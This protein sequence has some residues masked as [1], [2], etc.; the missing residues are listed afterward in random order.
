MAIVRGGTPFGSWDFS[1]GTHGWTTNGLVQ[2]A[3]TTPAGWVMDLQ[4]PDPSLTSPILDFP[5]NEFVQV[6][7]RMRS[8]SGA[9]GQLYFGPVFSEANSRGFVV[10][11]DDQWHE[12][13]INL[14]PL[15]AGARLRLDPGHDAGRV[16][17]S[18]IRA[19]T[20][21]APPPEPWASPAELRRKKLIGSGQYTTSGGESAVTSR[22]LA[23]NPAF[24]A[25]YPFDGLVLPVVVE[26]AVAVRL[27]LPA[28][29][30]F[31]HELLWNTVELP[32]AVIASAVADLKS[33]HWGGVTD[34]FLNYTLVDGARGR[35]T[36][37]FANDRDWAILEHNAT[38]AARLCREAGFQGFWLD[39]EQYGNYRWRTAT[40]VPE[41][42]PDRPKNLKFPL[43]KDTPELLRR[44]GA[45]WIR[46]VQ[47]EL[48]AVKIM[49]TFAWSPD[50][51]GYEPLKGVNGFLDGVLD[52]IQAP[53]QLIHGYENT[54]YYGQG[55]GTTHTREGFAGDRNRYAAARESM[56]QWRAFSANPKKY[57]AFL[58]VGM[59]AWVEDDPWSLWSGYTSG[60]TSSFWSNLPLALA[61]SD[62]YV[63]VWSEHTHYAHGF[64]A[65]GRINPFLASLHNQTFNTDREPVV[66]I[67]EDFASDPLGQGWYFDFDM[68]DI[69]RRQNPTHA[70]PLMTVDALPYDWS[71]EQRSV[72]I[73]GAWPAKDRHQPAAPSDGQRRRFVRPV[74]PV[75]RA[76]NFHAELDFMVASFGTHPENPMVLGLF[77]HDHPVRE[78]SLTF[79][80]EAPNRCRIVLAHE[81]KM[82]TFPLSTPNGLQTNHTYR[83]SL[84]YTASNGRLRATLNE[85]RLGAKPLARVQGRIRT[86][87]GSFDWDEFGAALAETPGPVAPEAGYRCWLKKVVFQR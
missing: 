21:P 75:N 2:N 76:K 6:N 36:P 44:R 19:E 67:D 35:F 10:Q 66:S 5:A 55:P 51:N 87:N 40:G 59:A 3:R 38:M 53:A 83:V 56:R 12:Y 17:V 70:V 57:D 77:R 45:Q 33:I 34:N 43:G 61:Y 58:K 29:D 27:G 24:L 68:L 65:G 18:W 25:S 82:R 42:D 62:E 48:P 52:G 80:I 46:A 85:P 78:K 50:A 86:A 54:F 28:R 8:T 73:D 20:S 69:G 26:S 32:E 39:T 64:Q 9:L 79:Q 31:L 16:T 41:F 47:S 11:S 74:Q 22:F 72:R 13:Q 81:G 7:I 14:P 30:Y 1:Q 37:D 60:L 15:G 23:Q 4:S 49:I 71:R 63:W 84:E